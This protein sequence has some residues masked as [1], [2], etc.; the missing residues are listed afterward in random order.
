MAAAKKAKTNAEGARDAAQKVAE[1]GTTNVEVETKK[2][3]GACVH[4]YDLLKRVEV[5]QDQI[6]IAL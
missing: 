3:D 6:K 4:S 5:A 2:S 1:D